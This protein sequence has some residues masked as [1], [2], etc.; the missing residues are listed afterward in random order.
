MFAS[1]ALSAVFTLVFAATAVYSLVRLSRLLAGEGAPG[2]RLVE[3]FHLVMSLA[4]V[5]MTWAWTGGPATPSGVL[6]IVVFGGFTMWFAHRAVTRATAHGHVANGYHVAMGAAM[7]W[8]VA[9]MPVIMGMPAGMGS[10]E[11]HAGHHGSGDAS[12]MAG[13]DPSTAAPAPG[14]TVAVS[15]V[16]AVVLVVAAGWWAV[17]AV[18]ADDPLPEDDLVSGGG[19]ATLAPVRPTVRADAGCHL[20]MSLGMAG[21]LVAML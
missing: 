13:M 1:T 7:T 6:Q 4:M 10:D 20:L 14:W 3:V 11:G 19:I 5:A 8:M 12:A 15:V 2:D 21:M 16:L 17:R 9:A 18:R